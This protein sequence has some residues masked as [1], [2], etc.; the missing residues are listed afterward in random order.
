MAYDLHGGWESFT[1]IHAALF[2]GPN[3][4]TPANVDE[5]VQLLLGYGVPREKIIMGIP[6]YGIGFT[7][8]NPNNNGVGAPTTSGGYGTVYRTLC[9]RINSG[10]WNDRWEEAQRVPY[11][12]L[13]SD[14][15]GYD[16]V[17]SVTEKAYYINQQ[18]LGGAMFWHLDGDDYDN[19]C[20]FGYHPIIRTVYNIIM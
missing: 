3:D 18:N 10:A 13:G 2:R 4:N 9:Q 6:A 11:M 19:V 1:G 16:N 8:A 14:W 20:G 12:F 15:I 5:S 17:R 7:L